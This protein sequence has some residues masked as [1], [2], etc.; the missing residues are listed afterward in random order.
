MSSSGGGADRG[1]LKTLFD[2]VSGVSKP[3]LRNEQ[4]LNPWKPDISFPK[5]TFSDY[6]TLMRA[7]TATKVPPKEVLDRELPVVSPNMSMISAPPD[8]PE[9]VQVTWIGH[10]SYLVQF[11]GVNILTDPVWSERCSPLPFAGPKRYRP[12]PMTISSLPNIDIVVVSHNHYDHLDITAVRQL[13]K[14]VLWLVPLGLK[15]WFNGK[16]IENV[17]EMN[18]WDEYQYNN[19]VSVVMTPCQHWTR[20]YAFADMNRTLWGS[21]LIKSTK[22]EGKKIYFS[23]DTG[24]CDAFKETRKML[25]S[26]DLAFIP[27]GAYSPPQIMK[28]QHIDPFEAVE[29]H[30]DLGANISIGMHWG[31]FILTPEPVLQPRERLQQAL[32]QQNI[33][34]ETFVT[35]KHGETRNMFIKTKAQQQRET[36]RPTYQIN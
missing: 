19:Y 14:S 16:G 23:G 7:I 36:A 31:T 21:F 1:R 11:D 10:S 32:Q 6:I 13:P 35:F 12:V 15:Q 5:L 29:V 33:N 34:P 2:G 26:V 3:L 22:H 17:V 30:K 25:G 9:H 27:I 28:D 8:T 20:R 4:Y 18:W 24:Y